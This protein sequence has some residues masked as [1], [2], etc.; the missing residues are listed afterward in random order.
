MS[1]EISQLLR[2]SARLLDL[3]DS[4][5]KFGEGGAQYQ[6]EDR[7][8]RR[9]GCYVAIATQAL[10]TLREYGRKTGDE[11]ASL[12][13]L[14][15]TLRTSMPWAND[16]D[17]EFVLNV[18]SRPTE[19]FMMRSENGELGH[20][21]SDK[22]TNL[23]DKAP[24]I[25]EFRLSGAGRRALTM[26]TELEEEFHDI[27]YMEGD[28]TKLIRALQRGKMEVALGFVE[29][30]IDQLRGEHLALIGL[31]ERGGR[32]LRQ[33]FDEILS[34]TDVMN[35]SQGLVRTA[36]VHVEDIIRNDR[37][38]N[39][40]VPVGMVRQRILELSRG[41]VRYSRELSHLAALSSVATTS[42]VSA[43]SF[44]ALARLWV[45]APLSGQRCEQVMDLI[46]PAAVFGVNP[47][48]T[49]FEGAI[50][51][52]SAQP[53]ASVVVA[54]GEYDLPPEHEFVQWL[55]RNR[56]Q[57]EQRVSA[58]GLTFQQAISMGLADDEGK[59][60][61]NCLV[62]AMASIETWCEKEGL[63]ISLGDQLSKSSLTTSDVMFSDFVLHAKP[64]ERIE[65]SKP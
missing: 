23:V 37:A 30:L 41:I 15:Q 42:S 51:Q 17:I 34:H 7:S 50:K 38:V 13:S 6:N 14:V 12:V 45:T 60:R 56:D 59:D 11:F 36:Q 54:L 24:N 28:V 22:E 58:E 29:K 33:A 26:A 27:G 63:V 35:R 47:M 5:R 57:I 55:R 64:T 31:I 16:V 4:Y 19:L 43:P 2:A 52:R 44:A 8:G 40:E 65:E 20:V 9:D 1:T 46:G 21:I 62:T 39:G 25:A 48:G 18:L 49:D 53:P 32:G 10:F 61:F 3:H